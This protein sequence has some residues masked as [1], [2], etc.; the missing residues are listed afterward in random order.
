MTRL[1]EVDAKGRI[2]IQ[3]AVVVVRGE[4]GQVVEAN[5]TE[6]SLMLGTASGGVIGLLIGII[7]GPLGMLIGG[8]GGLY[9]GA[10]FDIQDA[11]EVESALAAISRSVRVGRTALLAVVTEQSPD[12]IDTSMSGLGGT[13]LRRSVADVEAEVAAEKKAQ[14]KAKLADRK[15][16]IRGRQQHSKA[17]ISAQ[18][19]ELKDKRP[20]TA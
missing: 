8:A 17:A 5:R 6:S 20:R 14:R 9:A 7:G 4:D 11:G 2:V 15:E 12:V 18:T 1:K 16:L 3:Q 19:A 13:V 10:L